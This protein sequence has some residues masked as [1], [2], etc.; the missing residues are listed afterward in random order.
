MRKSIEA[1]ALIVL[2]YLSWITYWALNG[3]DRLPDRVPTHFD[4][5]GQPNA[6]G[7]PGI[8]WILPAVGAGL[9][10]L[11]TA[12]AS[13]QFRSYNLPV[14][15]T[16]ANLPLIQQKTSEMIAWIKTEM[17]CLFVYIQSGIIRGARLGSFRLSPTIVPVV[18]V[19]IFATL[20]IYMA[21]IIRGA[22]ARAESAV[23][24]E[25]LRND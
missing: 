15:V 1:L 21:V 8:L 17:L 12:L 22:K 20:G 24:G 13:I 10:L 5:S 18:M 6:W 16:E 3:P 11:M 25:Y 14:R 2:G 23:P 9:Y 7:S 19:A 4:I